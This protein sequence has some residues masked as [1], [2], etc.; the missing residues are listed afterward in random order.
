[1][2]GDGIAHY[3]E[4]CDTDDLVGADC[5]GAGDFIAGELACAD[6]CTFDTTACIAPGCGNGIVEEGEECDGADLAGAICFD[7]DGFIS[8]DLGCADDCTFDTAACSDVM[9]P[10]DTCGDAIVIDQTALPY[11]NSS[12]TLIYSNDYGYSSGSCPGETGG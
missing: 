9:P 12:N 3:G 11:T 7:F 8:G 5:L 6:D 10:G 1:M 2:C 4:V